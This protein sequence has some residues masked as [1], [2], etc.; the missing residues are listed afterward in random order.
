MGSGDLILFKGIMNLNSKGHLNTGFR[1]LDPV[2][3]AIV[4][5]NPVR[6][7]IMGV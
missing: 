7:D 3:G 6:K 2:C 4:E 5:G 1:V